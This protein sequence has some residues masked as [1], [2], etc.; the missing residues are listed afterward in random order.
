MSH[1]VTK[2]INVPL[3]E[4]QLGRIIKYMM[5]KNDLLI[6][7][8]HEFSDGSIRD[9]KDWDESITE[10]R[11]KWIKQNEQIIKVLKAYRDHLISSS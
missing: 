6:N 9:T 4:F 8:K 2:K 5:S 10:L 3:T 11:G 7:R 1:D